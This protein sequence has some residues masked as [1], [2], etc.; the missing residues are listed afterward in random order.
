[1]PI[2]DD[3]DGEDET[4]GEVRVGVGVTRMILVWKLLMMDK[5]RM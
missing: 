4:S 1:M 3:G 2:T 5:E